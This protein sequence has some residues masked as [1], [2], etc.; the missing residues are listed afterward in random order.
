M[1]LAASGRLHAHLGDDSRLAARKKR[2]FRNLLDS[3]ALLPPIAALRF[4]AYR[5]AS[6]RLLNW[7]RHWAGGQ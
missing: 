7:G 2:I 3:Q 5:V 1:A 4:Q 6:R